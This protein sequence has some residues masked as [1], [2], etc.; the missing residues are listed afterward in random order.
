MKYIDL[1]NI[2]KQN[3]STSVAKL[4]PFVVRLIIKIIRQN[5]LNRI[6][7][8]YSDYTGVDFLP[9][10]IDEFNITI[11]V[12]GLENL[13]EHGRCFFAAN[14][15]FGIIDGLI[16]THIV[17]KRYGNF[18]AIGNDVFHFIP[19]LK[20]V[21]APVNVFGQN[22]KENIRELEKLF[23][24]ETPI[25]HFPAGEVSR[26]YNG[27]VQDCSW[28]KSFINKAVK[29]KRDIVPI[30]FY[31]RN[32][33]FF[34]TL[35]FI[36]KILGIKTNIEL[37]LLPREMFRKKNKTI[38]VKIGKPISSEKFDQS[39]T[40]KEWAQKVRSHVYQMQKT[41]GSITF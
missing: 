8:D 33:L 36:R 1:E 23:D 6:L 10:I 14:H 19:H 18:K 9:K 4:P 5:E 13:P 20:P 29:K 22:V 3:P 30:Y 17:A 26:L 37:I 39:L 15:P 25:T 21:I 24:S 38:K 40:Y 7:N 27:K 31:G 12:D 32:S 28:Q 11:K 34:Y 41:N 35:G 16:I 2:I